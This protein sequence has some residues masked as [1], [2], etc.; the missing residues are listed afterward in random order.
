MLTPISSVMDVTQERIK[1][2]SCSA[3]LA[4]L[5]AANRCS[6]LT[7]VFFRSAH[8]NK[9]EFNLSAVVIKLGRSCKV[10]SVVANEGGKPWQLELRQNY[11]FQRLAAFTRGWRIGP[12]CCSASLPA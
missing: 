12:T 9:S 8:T 10:T 2:A 4:R 1:N 3:C 7:Q 11:I 6:R 5:F